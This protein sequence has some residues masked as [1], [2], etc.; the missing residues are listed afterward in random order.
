V[1]GLFGRAEAPHYLRGRLGRG[2]DEEQQDA[3]EAEARRVLL[4]LRPPPL[5]RPL[6]L[7]GAVLPPLPPLCRAL[8]LCRPT[9]FGELGAVFL[10]D[11]GCWSLD[12]TSIIGDRYDG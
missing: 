7:R 3:H 2:E 12:A 6:R 4:L 11:V 5:S 8:P 1:E 9:L 10:A